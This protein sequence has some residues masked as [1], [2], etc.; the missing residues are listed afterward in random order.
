MCNAFGRNYARLTSSGWSSAQEILKAQHLHLEPGDALVGVTGK[1]GD[2]GM[3]GAGRRDPL[4]REM[5][6]EW[7]ER[8]FEN[9]QPLWIVV[10]SESKRKLGFLR[11]KPKA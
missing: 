6:L 4:T 8:A 9:N 5:A 1:V 7:V 2:M 10:K 11:R 3:D